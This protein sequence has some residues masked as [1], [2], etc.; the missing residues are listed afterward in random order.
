MTSG[1]RELDLFVRESLLRGLER[2][3]I[4]KAMTAAGWTTDQ[5]QAA[6]DSYGDLPFPVPVPRPRPQ[7]SAREAFLYLLLFTTL[8]LSSYHLG[9]LLFDLINRLYPDV[10]DQTSVASYQADSMRWSVSYL[11]IAFPAFAFLARYVAKD[12]A[13][14]PVKRLSPIRRWL[15][16]LTLFVASSVLIG[17]LTTLVYNVLAGELTIRI[18]LKVAVVV[19]IAGTVLGY[20]LSDLRKEEHE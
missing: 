11:I 18:T 14:R 19:L 6:M 3:S 9:S 7:L 13:R 1:P 5:A 15:T 17:D 2:E 4:R 16:Y 10:A 20:Y 12:V 8:Y